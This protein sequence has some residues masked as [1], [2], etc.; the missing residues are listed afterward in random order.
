MEQEQEQ[1]LELELELGRKPRNE[2]LLGME[3]G[4]EISRV[5]KVSK[6]KGNSKNVSTIQI[7]TCM[8]FDIEEATA[9]LAMLPP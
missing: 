7:Q 2:V 4:M 8:E 1:E 6:E 3:R 5:V 9:L